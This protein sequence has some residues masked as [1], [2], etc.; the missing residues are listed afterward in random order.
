M[1]NKKVYVA[2][3]NEGTVR[4]EL[5]AVL[6]DMPFQSK[7]DVYI[8]YPND[9]PISNNRN[10]IVQDFLAHKEYDYLLMIDDDIIPPKNILNLAD[11]QKDIISAMTFMYQQ[12][13]VCPLILKKNNEGTYG[14]AQYKGYEGLVE[15]DTVGT[16]CVMLS[17]KVLEAIKRPFEDVFDEDGVRKYGL[18]ISF[19]KKAL[20]AGFQP[21]L[22]LDYPCGHRVVMDLKEIYASLTQ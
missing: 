22:H 7:Y 1:K 10:K 16:G 14:M 17:R 18:D 3:L 2:V 13:M 20:E 12:N 21:Y 6:H 4:I 19:G 9:K 8:T 15:V 5:A 11:F